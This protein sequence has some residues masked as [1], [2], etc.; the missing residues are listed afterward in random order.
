METLALTQVKLSR[1]LYLCARQPEKHC[2]MSKCMDL[3]KYLNMKRDFSDCDFRASDKRDVNH[4]PQAGERHLNPTSG[5]TTPQEINPS[6]TPSFLPSLLLHFYRG[7]QCWRTW[8]DRLKW[9][10]WGFLKN[11]W[12]RRTESWD[13]L[14]MKRITAAFYRHSIKPQSNTGHVLLLYADDTHLY[15]DLVECLNHVKNT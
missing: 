9:R 13:Y 7:L 12:R 10:H 8:T 3:A 15:L 6:L 14:L 5:P 1:V 2:L 4:I 11:E